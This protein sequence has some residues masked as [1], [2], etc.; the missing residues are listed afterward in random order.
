MP[1]FENAI[2]KKGE[3]GIFGKM[4]E[5]SN[6]AVVLEECGGRCVRK[7]ELKKRPDEARRFVHRTYSRTEA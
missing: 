6:V 4:G 1:G 5:F 2:G 3:N 7:K